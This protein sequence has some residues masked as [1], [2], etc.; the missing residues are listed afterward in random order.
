VFFKR[1]IS[2]LNE[3]SF[4]SNLPNSFKTEEGSAPTSSRKTRPNNSKH[5]L[6]LPRRKFGGSTP[7]ILKSAKPEAHASL[8]VCLLLDSAGF[9]ELVETPNER[10]YYIK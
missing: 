2:R 1:S 9:P 6:H 5:N 10:N 8:R 4:T 7:I 3:I